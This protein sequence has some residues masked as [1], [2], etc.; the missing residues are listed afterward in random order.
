[1][2][3][4]AARSP[5]R[6]A[7]LDCLRRLNMALDACKGMLYSD[8]HALAVLCTAPLKSPN[9]LVDRHWRVKISDFNPVCCWMAAR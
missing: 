3:R 9:L 6:A 7:Q 4:G 1:M 8:S 2:L 5:A